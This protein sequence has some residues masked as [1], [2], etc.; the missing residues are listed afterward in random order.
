MY[1]FD[2]FYNIQY[3][4]CIVVVTDMILDRNP[5]EEMIKA[6]RLF[7]DD[8]TGKININNLRRVAKFV[9]NSI[10]TCCLYLNVSYN[11]E[12]WVKISVLKS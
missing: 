7:D 3:T 9:L 10:I 5:E 11:P 4:E 6:F 12:N 8:G 1:V 2:Y